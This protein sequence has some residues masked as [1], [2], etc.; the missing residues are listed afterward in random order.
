MDYWA[1]PNVHSYMMPF[2]PGIDM[3]LKKAVVPGTGND[4][5]SMT[6]TI[7]LARFIVRLLDEPN[8]PKTA[9][10]SG[11]DATFNEIIALLEKYHSE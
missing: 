11:T 6:Y 2:S 3:S 5:M 10:I 7:D 4:V 9:S 8:W 1:M